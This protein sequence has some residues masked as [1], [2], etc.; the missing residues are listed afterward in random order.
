MPEARLPRDKWQ[1]WHSGQKQNGHRRAGWLIRLSKFL[2][3]DQ[4]KALK[5]Q[6]WSTEE[7]D[8]N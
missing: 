7:K 8:D 6:L 3:W 4:S 1:L 2:A 5:R